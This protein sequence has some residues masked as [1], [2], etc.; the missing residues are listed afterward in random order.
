MFYYKLQCDIY[1]YSGILCEG[2]VV[3]FTM[4]PTLLSRP[5]ITSGLYEVFLLFPLINSRQS[6]L[7]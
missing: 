1:I 4:P 7:R 3:R 5:Y 2:Y 6:R